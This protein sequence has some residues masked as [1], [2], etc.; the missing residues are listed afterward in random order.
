MLF[1]SWPCQLVSDIL[2]EILAP[3]DQRAAQ[4]MRCYPPASPR[5]SRRLEISDVVEQEMTWSLTT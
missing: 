1:I 3:L 5:N 4:L 2:T